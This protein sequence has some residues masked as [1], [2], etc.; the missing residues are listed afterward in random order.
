MARRKTNRTS[1]RES[2]IAINQLGGLIRSQ[3][4]FVTTTGRRRNVTGVQLGSRSLTKASGRPLNNVKLRKATRGETIRNQKAASV[5]T[6]SRLRK[7]GMLVTDR[8]RTLGQRRKV[9]LHTR[10][11]HL[12]GLASQGSKSRSQKRRD[13]FVATKGRSKS[14]A[15]SVFNRLHPRD[16]RGRFRRK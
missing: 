7:A 1:Q 6:R 9:G 14:G 3:S 2:N 13:V 11:P 12:G 5:G 10:A 4:S 16:P 8:T 15:R